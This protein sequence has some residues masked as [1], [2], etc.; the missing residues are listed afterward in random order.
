[1]A[2]S[3]ELRCPF[4]DHRLIEQAFRMP[5]RMKV[6]RL[7]DS[8]W[9]ASGRRWLLRE[10]AAQQESFYLPLEVF[11]QRPSSASWSG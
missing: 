3:L 10:R 7:V 1:M 6:R 4:L 2:H 11:H 9:S 5:D 8:G